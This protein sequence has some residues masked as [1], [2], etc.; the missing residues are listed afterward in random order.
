MVSRRPAEARIP[1]PMPSP[2]FSSLQ[3]GWIA[4]AL[5]AA[6]SG[7]GESPELL[8]S[9]SPVA[10]PKTPQPVVVAASV[11]PIR[12]GRDVRPILSDRCFICH[13][14]DP[15]MRK[16]DLRLDQRESATTLR[17]G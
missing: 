1:G 17:N 3:T 2:I 12:F 15:T 16:A 10:Q 6:L 7:C 4:A 14:P 11:D 5:L 13:G 9:A 8:A